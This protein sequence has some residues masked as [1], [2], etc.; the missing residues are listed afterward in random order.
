MP[1]ILEV[2]PDR[3]CPYCL[4]TTRSLHVH[5]WYRDRGTGG[6]RGDYDGTHY[7]LQAGRS[8]FEEFFRNLAERHPDLE[9]LDKHLSPPPGRSRAE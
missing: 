8:K 5:L 1:E 3:R 6:P 9:P 2:G 7:D 4:D